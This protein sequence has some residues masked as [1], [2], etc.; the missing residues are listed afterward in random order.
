M[1]IC[2][3]CGNQS[4]EGAV[5][6]DQCGTRLPT[7]EATV[8][9]QATPPAAASVICSAC[10][11]GNVPGEAFCD[12][13]GSPLEAPLPT[14]IAAP[15]GEAD[16]GEAI[17]MEAPEPA[18]AV[19][20][21]ESAIPAAGKSPT[22]PACGAETQPDEAF[23]PDCGASLAAAP[24]PPEPVLEAEP[25]PPAE[26]PVAAEQGPEAGAEPK[27]P[28]E[29]APAPEPDTGLEAA[30]KTLIVEAEPRPATCPACGV[31]VEAGDR[32][33]SNCGAVLE[34]AP[35]IVETPSAAPFPGPR[36]TVL[37]SGA[38]IPLPA[39]DEILIG[40]ED[41]ISGIYPDVDLTPHDGEA[42]G[43][44]RRHARLIVEGGKTFVEDLD[45]TN[46]TFV[47]RQ[48]LVPKTRHPLNDGDE[49]RCGRVPLK[50]SE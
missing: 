27:A 10:G 26:E 48:R 8:V 24:I 6:C 33:C 3:N 23:C 29:V 40:R 25:E 41:P 44:S 39:K 50:F 4:G 12:F 21:A 42:G 47:N 5:F 49:L 13:C 2:Q 34:A 20:P 16:A 19:A 35:P 11:A 22:C 28:P 43:V 14:A 9:E 15:E 46:Y 31:E 17:S 36:L 30:P 1:P 37:S 38:E 32:F 7:P 18:E 45:S